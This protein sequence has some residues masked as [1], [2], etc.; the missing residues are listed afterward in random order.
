MFEIGSFETKN[1]MFDFDYQKMIVF[2]FFW[3]MLEKNVCLLCNLVNLVKALLGWKF[4]V[5]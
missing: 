3:C 2:H 5:Q 1:R 4:D